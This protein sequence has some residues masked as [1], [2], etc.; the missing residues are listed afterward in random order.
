M[1]LQYLNDTGQRQG[2]HP[3]SDTDKHFLEPCESITIDVPEGYIGF[4]KSWS[5]IVLITYYRDE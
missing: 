2:I 4:V 1:K 5:N 3:A